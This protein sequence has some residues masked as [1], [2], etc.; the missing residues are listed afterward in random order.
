MV[1][2]ACHLSQSLRQP[3]GDS[4]PVLDFWLSALQRA[5][6]EDPFW[7]PGFWED[8]EARA[9]PLVKGIQQLVQQCHSLWCLLSSN[10]NLQS[11]ALSTAVVY[12]PHP[13]KPSE[14]HSS[15]AN[16]GIGWVEKIVLNYWSTILGATTEAG[17][18]KIDSMS[19]HPILEILVRTISIHGYTNCYSKNMG[20]P[21]THD[22]MR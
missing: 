21:N 2:V 4:S 7:G 1:L 9:L 14:G 17:Q 12:R 10:G 20:F 3:S 19:S 11:S 16:E 13:S 8:I 15:L 18:K 22:M 6:D 5:M